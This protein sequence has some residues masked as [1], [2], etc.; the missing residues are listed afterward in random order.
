MQIRST[1]FRLSQNDIILMASNVFEEIA[2]ECALDFIQQQVLISKDID[3][4]DVGAL[5]SQVGSE[6]AMDVMS[7]RDDNGWDIANYFV[8]IGRNKFKA[9]LFINEEK[10]YRFLEEYD[11]R[12][13]TFNR[14]VVPDIES[15]SDK[16]QTLIFNTM[17]QG[18]MFYT[19][20]AIPNP[21]GDQSAM[22]ETNLYYQRYFQ[23]KK[24]LVKLLPQ[25]I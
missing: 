4:Y 7:I 19:Q 18:I 3:E 21:T 8:E 22:A 16:T 2:I 24:N 25:R 12:Y 23:A 13:I 15:I 5:Y 20:D 9:N 14:Q 1:N 11:G 6:V 17:L 10:N